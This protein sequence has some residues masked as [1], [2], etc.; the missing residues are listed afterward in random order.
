MF[1]ITP[2]QRGEERKVEYW[3][4]K[5]ADAGFDPGIVLADDLG[6]AVLSIDAYRRMVKAI[7]SPDLAG[8]PEATTPAPPGE[9][10]A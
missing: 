9:A 5:L 8:W 3:V 4:G 2:K 10:L 6:R 7:T 1:P